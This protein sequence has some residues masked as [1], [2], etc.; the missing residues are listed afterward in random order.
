M[1]KIPGGMPRIVTDE[2]F[3]KVKLRMS[4]NKRKA[5]NKAKEVYL[6]SGL[7]FCGE[8]NGA[9]IGHTSYSGRSKLKHSTY[10][11]STR[12]NQK[13]CTLKA[14]NKNYVEKFTL[15][16]IGQCILK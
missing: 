2:V 7:I 10:M 6:L 1:I 15:E 13:T 3:E 12:K 9:M 8:C 11:C 14:I 16:N 5:V 4:D